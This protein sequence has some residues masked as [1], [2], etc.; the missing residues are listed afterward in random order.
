MKDATETASKSYDAVCRNRNK[1]YDA[2]AHNQA[3]FT[4]RT[5]AV[6]AVRGVVGG[7]TTCAEIQIWSGVETLQQEEESSSDIEIRVLPF[8]LVAREHTCESSTTLS[9]L[10]PPEAVSY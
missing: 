6:V 10:I 7:L 1:V 8:I 3:S 5:A 4:G 9:S 2:A